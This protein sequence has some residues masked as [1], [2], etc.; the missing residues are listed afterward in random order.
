MQEILQ[1]QG[2]IGGKQMRFRCRKTPINLLSIQ[3][4]GAGGAPQLQSKT[5]TP[6]TSQQT[7][8]PDNGYDGLSSVQ[9]NAIS[10]TKGAETF[11][12]KTYNQTISSGR[13]L[14]GTQTIKGDA[15]LVSSNIKSGV[16]IFGVSGSLQAGEFIVVDGSVKPSS[17]SAVLSITLNKVLTQ[18]DID[19]IEIAYIRDAHMSGDPRDSYRITGAYSAFNSGYITWKDQS[20]DRLLSEYI[21]DPR[22]SNVFSF[23]GNTVT[24]NVSDRDSG[25]LSK[26]S[27]Y[28]T[29]I[30]SFF[31]RVT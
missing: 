1:K 6:S 14:T 13:W 24:I 29:Y 12:P 7:V 18:Q 19:N 10:P 3:V 2:M 9:V 16:S 4:F 22:T 15:N 11:T 25:R 23:N 26:F 20:Y 30:V 27:Q 5:V 21:G 31:I 28:Y 8:G 17:D